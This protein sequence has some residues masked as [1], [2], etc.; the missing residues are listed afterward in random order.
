V[1]YEVT[2]GCVDTCQQR[3]VAGWAIENSGPTAVTIKLNHEV[4]AEVS[5]SIP[6]PDVCSAF[7]V[8]GALG[9]NYRFPRA[10]RASDNLEFLIGKSGKSIPPV[11]HQKRIEYLMYRIPQADSG[12]EIGA[13]DNPFLDK[14]NFFVSYVDHDTREKLLIKYKGTGWDEIFDQAQVVE[15]DIVWQPGNSLRECANGQLFDYAIACHVMEH[16]ANPIR[17]LNDIGECLRPGGRIN[18]ALPDMRR[19]FDHCRKLSTPADM[20]E[21]FERDFDRP[22]FRAVFDHIATVANP[23]TVPDYRADLLRQALAVARIAESGEYVDVH[24]HVWTPESFRECWTVI[25]RLGLCRAKLEQIWEPGSA[26]N[27]FVVSLVV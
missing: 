15:T 14:M 9:F 16:V 25:D 10:I 1:A 26:S 11:P 18:L 8:E 4:L 13:L 5:T 12:M 19:T 3:N 7:G 27:E 23:P 2:E 22:R 20:I 17:W 24:C 6:R 21:A